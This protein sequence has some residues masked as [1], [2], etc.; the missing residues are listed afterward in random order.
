MNWAATYPFVINIAIIVAGLGVGA[1]V[2]RRTREYNATTNVHVQASRAEAQAVREHKPP[3]TPGVLKPLDLPEHLD[4]AGVSGQTAWAFDAASAVGAVVVPLFA[5]LDVVG[6]T[7]KLTGVIYS[8]GGLL[9]FLL[10]VY[11]IRFDAPCRWRSE[12]WGPL[13]RVSWALLVASLG[14]GLAAGLLAK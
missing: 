14:L 12:Y 5:L 11:V 6:D 8:F 4:V 9:G 1:L 10:L 2:D 3:G 13:S 7:G